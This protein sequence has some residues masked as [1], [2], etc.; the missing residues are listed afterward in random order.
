M[1]SNIREQIDYGLRNGNWGIEFQISLNNVT[2]SFLLLI[3]PYDKY[4]YT[5]PTILRP[6]GSTEILLFYEYGCF[7]YG[8]PITLGSTKVVYLIINALRTI[9]YI[10]R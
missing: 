6:G 8:P 5:C 10:Y 4:F 9:R 2:C 1:N 7:I 3:L